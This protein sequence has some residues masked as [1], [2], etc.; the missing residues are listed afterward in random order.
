MIKFKSSSSHKGKISC[1]SFLGASEL[2][3]VGNIG[4]EVERRILKEIGARRQP[5][6]GGIPGF[7]NDGTIGRYLIEV[8]STTK[9][10]LGL[11]RKWLEDLEENALTSGRI[12]VLVIV[13][14]E[15]LEIVKVAPDKESFGAASSRVQPQEWVAI[16]RWKFERLTK[17]WRKG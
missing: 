16:P 10:S 13:F 5:R 6:S 4:Q 9:K 11:K 1:C 15:R 8:K 7:P 3:P 12:P 14:P 17:N 2:P